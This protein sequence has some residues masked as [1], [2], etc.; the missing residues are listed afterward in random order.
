M[1]ATE[2]NTKQQTAGKNALLV[3]IGATSREN[4]VNPTPIC[5][6]QTRVL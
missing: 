2:S 1:A 5:C 6:E 3:T 4:A